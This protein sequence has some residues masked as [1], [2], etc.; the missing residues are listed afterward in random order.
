VLAARDAHAH[1]P[2]VAQNA[3]VLRDRGLR[4]AERADQLGDRT[5]AVASELEDAPP[6]RI[7]QRLVQVGAAVAHAEI[8]Y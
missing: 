2:R 3:Q 7:G 5:L 4:D 8:I 6:R 1:E